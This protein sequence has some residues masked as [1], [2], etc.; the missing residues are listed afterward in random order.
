MSGNSLAHAVNAPQ[1][2]RVLSWADWQARLGCSYVTA[3]RRVAAMVR[4]GQ[5]QQRAV[6]PRCGRSPGTSAQVPDVSSCP[7][8]G[9]R[10]GRGP[11]YAYHETVAWLTLRRRAS[12]A[13]DSMPAAGIATRSNQSANRL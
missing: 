5:L 1:A 10:F 2:W 13:F 8:C 3:R 12:S 4:A 6:C 7:H 11:S 9:R